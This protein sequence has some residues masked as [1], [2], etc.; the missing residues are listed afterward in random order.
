MGL[1]KAIV[2]AVAAL[3]SPTKAAGP[4]AIG[5]LPVKSPIHT[6]RLQTRLTDYGPEKMSVGTPILNG[7]EITL[8]K[9]KKMMA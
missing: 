5:R 7:P 6:R 1:A 2:A 4:R 3:S 9:E 8:F